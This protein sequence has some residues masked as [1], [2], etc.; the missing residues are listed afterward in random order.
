[1]PGP[2]RTP[3]K[4]LEARGSWLADARG[5]EPKPAPGAP[6]CPDWLSDDAR[7]IWFRICGHLEAM[8]LLHACDEAAI[9]RH[10]Q[11]M[12]RYIRVEARIQGYAD[13][14]AQIPEGTTG[15]DLASIM[16]TLDKW[17]MR[18]GALNDKLLKLERE[19]GLTPSARA[20]M[21]IETKNPEENRGKNRYF[22]KAS[23]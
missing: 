18:A 2:K 1:M 21:A 20:G 22:A 8:G 4:V 9:A 10:A 11:L 19:F 3:T 13:W 14:E 15:K 17:H 23:A 7:P 16:M 6:E 12:A 5:K